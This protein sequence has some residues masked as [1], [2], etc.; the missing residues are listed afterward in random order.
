MNKTKKLV[1]ISLLISQALILSI[2][3]SWI[4]VPVPV[5]GVKLGLA[6]IITVV[7]I[8][9]FSF[10]EAL[11]VVMIRTM[12]ISILGGGGLIVFL[13]SSVGG[14]LSAIVM[15]GLYKVKG[16]IFSIIGISIA[17]AAAH[18]IGQVL[19][20]TFLMRDIAVIT[21]LPLILVFGSVMGVLIGIVSSFL[22]RKLRKAKIFDT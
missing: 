20:A 2:I 17:G 16:D 3:E 15:A 8:I 18:N 13:F 19:V 7:V 21:I 1:L 9:F 11:T 22:E 4:P 6:N 5:P 10:K 12:I 14:I